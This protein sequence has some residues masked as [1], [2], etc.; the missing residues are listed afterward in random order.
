MSDQPRVVI[1]PPPYPKN[2]PGECGTG[3]PV[4]GRP[5]RLYAVGWRCQVHNPAAW[6][7]RQASDEAAA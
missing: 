6:A 5:A 1:T 4:C 7:A 3:R 2:V